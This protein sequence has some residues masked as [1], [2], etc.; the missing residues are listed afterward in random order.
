MIH[1]I[2][3]PVSYDKV[4][5]YTVCTVYGAQYAVYCARITFDGILSNIYTNH[6]KWQ[7]TQFYDTWFKPPMIIIKWQY[8]ML[9][10]PV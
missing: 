1:H 3:V 6:K 4:H 8:D 2:D 5:Y 7:F 10:G 9:S